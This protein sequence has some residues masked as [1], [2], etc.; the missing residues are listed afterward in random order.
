MKKFATLPLP[1]DIETGAGLS[2]FG[3]VAESAGKGKDVGG[4]TDEE[5]MNVYTV[6]THRS[7]QILYLCRVL[8]YATHSP[9]N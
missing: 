3:D 4:D 9:Y 2:P 8:T 5:G 7:T 1:I 6:E